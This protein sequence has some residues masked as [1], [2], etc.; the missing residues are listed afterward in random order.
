MLAMFVSTRW[1][2][3]NEFRDKHMRLFKPFLFI[4]ALTFFAATA[5][6]QTVCNDNR[7]IVGGVDTKIDDHPWQV[8]LAIPGPDGV[9]LCGGSLVQDRWVLTAAHCFSSKNPK[10]AKVKAGQ[11]IHSAGSWIDTGKVFVHE[12]YNEDTHENDIAL[13]KLDGRIAGDIIPLAQGG[14]D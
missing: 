2:P 14:E 11:T 10:S 9:E 3:C 1:N 5:I 6:A 8:A 7:R 12:A 4:F 13:V